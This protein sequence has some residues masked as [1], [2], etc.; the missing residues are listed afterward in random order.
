MATV[1]NR[2]ALTATCIE[3]PPP[4]KLSTVPAQHADLHSG[5]EGI[6]VTLLLHCHLTLKNLQHETLQ[7]MKFV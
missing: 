4:T 3:V 5:P 1:W 2:P 7:P 6:T